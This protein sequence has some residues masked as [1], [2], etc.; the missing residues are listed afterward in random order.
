VEIAIY[1][2]SG[3]RV[4]T[5]DLVHL[6]GGQHVNLWNGRSETGELVHPGIYL[7]QVTAKTGRGNFELTRPF[8]VAY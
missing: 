7:A 1:T 4:H 3:N 5:I 6:A 2:L 8:Y